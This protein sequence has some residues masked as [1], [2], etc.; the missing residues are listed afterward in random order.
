M[1]VLFIDLDD[2]KSVNDSFGHVAA[3]GF[4]AQA[5]IPI[6]GS[7]IG[8]PA[9]IGIAVGSSD[10]TA[11]DLLR[12]ADTS[13]YQSQ[14]KIGR[15]WES[16]DAFGRNLIGVIGSWVL[17]TACRQAGEWIRR[18]PVTTI[19]IDKSYVRGL[20]ADRADTAITAGVIALA[21]SLGLRTLA[22]GIETDDQYDRLH[23]L[24]CTDG[25][26]WLW[27]PALPA[28]QVEQL[29][30][31]QRVDRCPLPTPGNPR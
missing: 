2:F 24:Q 6:G 20:G 16:A 22:E 11:E 29:I 19:K 26:G 4:L 3:D 8:A 14:R 5:G 28:E 9:S 1:G 30:C 17:E 25:Q 18:L 13:M 31:S 7:R 10:S 12:E 27:Y 23:R 21:R 15:R